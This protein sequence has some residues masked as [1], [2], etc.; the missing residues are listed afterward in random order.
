M[1]EGFNKHTL[2]RSVQRATALEEGSGVFVSIFF[3][4]TMASHPPVQC[5]FNKFS[6]GK[7][8]KSLPLYVYSGVYLYFPRK[9]TAQ[10]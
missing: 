2:L 6:A 7:E 5:R 9:E 1:T 8:M 4:F 10:R 3:L